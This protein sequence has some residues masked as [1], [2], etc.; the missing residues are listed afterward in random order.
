M[1]LYIS[2]KRKLVSQ[3]PSIPLSFVKYTKF[4]I[5]QTDNRFH[6]LVKLKMAILTIYCKLM[7]KY[8]NTETLKCTRSSSMST[9]S[10]FIMNI[11]SSNG[12]LPKNK[13][14]FS[15]LKCSDNSR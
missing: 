9:E 1:R 12:T 8:F 11:K 4:P 15:V 14:D 5:N 6:G 3:K 7:T 13:V 10:K 2:V